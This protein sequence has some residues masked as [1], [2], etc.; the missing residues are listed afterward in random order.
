M[1]VLLRS[2]LLVGR[3]ENGVLYAMYITFTYI[4]LA[5]T[6]VTNCKERGKV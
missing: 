5:R 2:L 6:Q 3:E 1:E 4:P